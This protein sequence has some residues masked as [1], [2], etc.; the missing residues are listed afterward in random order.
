MRIA[1][2]DL[3]VGRHSETLMLRHLVA[4]IPRQRFVEF[5]RQLAR[6]LDQRIDDRLGIFASDFH[7]HHIARLTFNQ[8]GDLAIRIAEQKIPF[9]V[10][11][12]RTILNAGGALANR[13]GIGDSAVIARLLG[14]MA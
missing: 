12:Y 5:L 9:P 11:R 7:Q 13:H 3:D 4:P 10:T 14:V 1:E 8:G 6:M 2:V